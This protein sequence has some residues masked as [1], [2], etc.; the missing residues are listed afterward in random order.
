MACP[1]IELDGDCCITNFDHSIDRD[2][3]DK[4]RLGAAFS[5]HAAWDFCGRVWFDGNKWHEEVWVYGIAREIVTADTPEELM[6][7]VNAMYGG[8]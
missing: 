4:L 6:R 5:R 2:Q 3:I 7:T 1:T 8:D